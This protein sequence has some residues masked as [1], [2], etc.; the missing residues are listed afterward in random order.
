M[1]FSSRS[2]KTESEKKTV[3]FL[4]QYLCR[5]YWVK[6]T[7]HWNNWFDDKLLKYTLF[8]FACY[9]CCL[10]IFFCRFIFLLLLNVIYEGNHVENILMNQQEF[11]KKNCWWFFYIY[12]NGDNYNWFAVIFVG[13]LILIY[14]IFST[15]IEVRVTHLFDGIITDP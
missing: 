15:R 10:Y 3:F 14:T 12:C 7:I 9:A 4:F 1:H 8:F 5:T 11:Y 2:T 6:K 13:I